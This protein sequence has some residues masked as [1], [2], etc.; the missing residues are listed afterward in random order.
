MRF[1]LSMLSSSDTHT[2]II[3]GSSSGCFQDDD[4]RNEKD[5][6]FRIG[7]NLLPFSDILR[8]CSEDFLANSCVFYI[9]I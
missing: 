9:Q 5:N 8:S 3:V 6:G 1:K 7:F 2:Q 4:F